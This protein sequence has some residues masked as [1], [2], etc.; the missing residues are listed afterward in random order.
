MPPLGYDYLLGSGVPKALPPLPHSLPPHH[1][2]RG[3]PW[4]SHVH[5]AP[6]MR[7]AE[8]E[9]CLGPSHIALRTQKEAR[10]SGGAHVD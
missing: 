6:G 9:A 1:G 10:L 8:A 7:A 3:I 2:D 5:Q 4:N